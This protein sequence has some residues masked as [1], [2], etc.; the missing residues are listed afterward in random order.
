[1]DM[2]IKIQ[3]TPLGKGVITHIT[4]VRTLSSMYTFVFSQVTFKTKTFTTQN[5]GKWIVIIMPGHM[6]LQSPQVTERH[7]THI[8][9]IW[10]LISMN[11]FMLLPI[12]FNGKHFVTNITPKW[13][14][15][16]MHVLM[17]VLQIKLRNKCFFRHITAL[18]TMTTV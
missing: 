18:W 11:D 5:K 16:T 2:V 9:P 15:F 7:I 3:S 1:M 10:S 4:D 14:H 13:P 8:T 12:S 6:F 17:M